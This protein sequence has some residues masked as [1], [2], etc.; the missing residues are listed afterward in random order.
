MSGKTHALNAFGRSDVTLK[1]SI[2]SKILT[3][4]MILISVP[5][6]IYAIM[7][8]TLLASG[9][10][11]WITS[12]YA[13]K[14]LGYSLKELIH[15]I[16]SPIALSCGMG[17]F[18]ILIG[19]I[20]IGLAMGLFMQILGGIIFY[21]GLSEILKLEQYEYLKNLILNILHKN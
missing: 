12:H 2:I 11:F 8:G 13:N 4:V 16:G 14:Y 7:W 3:L 20:E 15:D 9:I 19:K 17:I 5:M 10:S 21:V 18:V 1:L 6:G